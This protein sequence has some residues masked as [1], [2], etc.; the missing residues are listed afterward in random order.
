MS[1][2][3]GYGP[4]GQRVESIEP[5]QPPIRQTIL[6][7]VSLRGILAP[8]ILEGAM[9]GAIFVSWLKQE[10]LPVMLPG[11]ILVLD[12]LAVHKVL[13][14]AECVEKA[15]MLLLYLPP[16]SPDLSPIEPMWSKIKAFMRKVGAKTLG[17][18]EKTFCQAMDDVTFQ[19]I[20]NWFRHCGYTCD[21]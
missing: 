6:A 21:T 14:V 8:F 10:L 9:D 15:G 5:L 20:F 17:E 18:M 13:A 4:K 11:E 7:G 16:Y 12:N 2:T 3:H 1:R 19:H